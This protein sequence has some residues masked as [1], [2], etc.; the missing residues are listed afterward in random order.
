MESFRAK[1]VQLSTATTE[2]LAVRLEA[3]CGLASCATFA[4]ER[5]QQ[6]DQDKYSRGVSILQMPADI[7]EWRAEHRTARKRA[8]RA[9]RLGYRFAEIDRSRHND[10][11]HEINI[12]LPRRQGRP[13][14][15]GYTR[16]HEHGPL[17][18]Y[19]CDR[20]RI[21]TFGILDGDKLRA[22]LTLYRVGELG[23]VSMILGH[24]QHLENDIMYLLAAGLIA[25]QAHHGGVLFYNRHDSGT[26]GLRYYKERV[27]FQETDVEWCL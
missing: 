19:R 14:S 9:H 12:S 13:M 10:A 16:R 11:I 26:D 20:H 18:Q 2:A 17:P 23:L 4:Y 7:I 15:A 8:D 21:H 25:D 22:Y 24:G 5:F 27:G 3:G 1:G 6:L